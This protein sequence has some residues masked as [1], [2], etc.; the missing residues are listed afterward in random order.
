MAKPKSRPARWAEAAGNAREALGAVQEAMA[1]LD[2]ALKE[3][4]DIR[5]EYEEW[6]DNMPE[7]LQSGPTGEK[8]TEITG[9]EF[10]QDVTD[11]TLGQIEELI[12]EAENADLPLGFGKD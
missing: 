4:E 9:M 6:Y 3:L 8:L 12:D 5:A 7:G 2:E 11:M 10:D 1:P